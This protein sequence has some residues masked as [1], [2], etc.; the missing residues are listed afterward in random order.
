M[1][2]YLSYTFTSGPISFTFSS[3]SVAATG[4]DGVSATAP[5]RSTP[6][7]TSSS[8]GSAASASSTI[9]S[10]SSN[11]VSDSH[12]S[13]GGGLSQGA[14]IGIAVCAT[15]VGLA[16]LGLIFFFF[17]RKRKHATPTQQYHNPNVP[18]PMLQTQQP[19]PDVAGAFPHSGDAFH[20]NNFDSFNA[21]FSQMDDDA[22]AKLRRF[23][24]D[25]TIEQTVAGRTND[26]FRP[27]AA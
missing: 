6:S 14:I 9:A 11:D 4:L 10:S 21:N 18:P 17:W 25:G 13:G 12:S 3:A 23:S 1:D 26:E 8:S 27:Q 7:E 20:P 16:I 15:V 2:A 22:V 24:N 5:T 19:P